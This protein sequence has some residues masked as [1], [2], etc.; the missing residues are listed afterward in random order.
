MELERRIGALSTVLISLIRSLAGWTLAGW[1]RPHETCACLLVGSLAQCTSGALRAVVSSGGGIGPVVA[2][3]L[4]HANGPMISGFSPASGALR[5]IVTVNGSG[6]LFNIGG[7]SA[8]YR[9]HNR[10]WL[11]VRVPDTAQTGAIVVATTG[12]KETNA[13]DFTVSPGLLL[14]PPNRSLDCSTSRERSRSHS[15]ADR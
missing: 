4:A 11:D 14:N 2:P 13:M 6:L 1:R 12:G 15:R 5:T 7:V 10:S 9:I 8:S 3:R